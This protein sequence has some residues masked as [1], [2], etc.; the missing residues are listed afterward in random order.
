MNPTRNQYLQLH[1]IILLWGFTPILGKFISLEATDLVWYR[2]LIS[3]ITLYA[4]MRCKRIKPFVGISQLG[5]IFLMGAI[6]GFHW[7]F[8]YHAIKVS[9]VS[10]AL[11]G[12]AT[13]TLFA[14][15]LQPLLLNKPFALIDLVY[16]LLV[17]VGLLV[18]IQFESVYIEGLLYGVLAALTG[19]IFGVYN[20]K[21]IAKHEATT[22]TL[23]EFAG[24]FIILTLMKIPDGV[25]AFIH[26]L[27]IRDLLALLVLSIVCTTLAF[28]WSI[29]I[30]KFFSPF[31]VIVTN[32]LEPVYGIVFS[33]ILFGQS[34]RMS[35]GF[36]A[37]TVIIML[38]VFTYPWAKQRFVSTAN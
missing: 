19:A 12:F 5:V 17:L 2:L 32:N 22:I 14:S 15:L 1:I 38:S 7:F 37:G 8:F 25:D 31:T 23:Y 35:L 6:V 9:N 21:L 18:I 3:G 10:M 4:Y 33:V 36:Y 30:L 11:S 24:A 13:M 34:E 16:G 27:N 26:A 28:T 20:G 29:H